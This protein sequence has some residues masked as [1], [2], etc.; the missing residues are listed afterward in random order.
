MSTNLLSKAL[1]ATQAEL[2]AELQR[3]QDIYYN[4]S[5]SEVKQIPSDKLYDDLVK[6]YESRFGEYKSIGAEPRGKEKVV[7][8]VFMG[9]LKKARTAKELDNFLKKYPGKE[10]VIMDKID[11]ISILDEPLAA[12]TRGKKGLGTDVTRVKHYVKFPPI[13]D[14]MVRGELAIQKQLF[15]QKYKGRYEN[16]RNIIFGS[17]TADDSFDPNVVR[18]FSFLAY[19]YIDN[20]I[21]PQTEQLQI[22]EKL[23]FQTPWY[24]VVP[25]Q[26]G[27]ELL[28]LLRPMLEKRQQE[29]LFDLDGLVLY[30]NGEYD[31]PD[32][33]NPDHSISFKGEDAS[34]ITR[35]EYVHWEPSKGRKLKPDVKVQQVYIDGANVDWATGNNARFIVEN[36]IDTGAIVEIVR[37]GKIIPKIIKVLERAE[38]KLPPNSYWNESGA[39][40]MTSDNTD[41]VN[42]KKLRY[43]F[44]TMDIKYLGEKT[45]EKLYDAGIDTIK[46]FLNLTVEDV[47]N[48]QGFALAGATRIVE[49]I[50][51]GI[52][53]ANIA[54]I[55]A[56][57]G[58]IENFAEKKYTKIL[59]GFPQFLDLSISNSDYILK[60][61]SLGGFAETAVTFAENRTKLNEFL[62]LHTEIT[63]RNDPRENRVLNI[64][65]I[66]SPIQGPVISSIPSPRIAVPSPIFQNPGTMIPV[67]QGLG[68]TIPIIQNDRVS[69]ERKEI[70]NSE[71][72]PI[73]QNIQNFNLAPVQ[74]RPGLL[75]GKGVLFTGFRNKEL[76]QRI[77]MQGGEIKSTVNGKTSI[78]VVKDMNDTKGKF[79]KAEEINDKKPG[80]IEIISLE[81]F[82]T[83]YMS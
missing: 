60:L 22:L 64:P 70:L 3:L 2:E 35:V 7:L 81:D 29:S 68:T 78:L 19:R 80:S 77:V 62:D 13:T 17:I 18:D 37:S 79:A 21:R 65:N 67:V 28:N 27:A 56:A 26:T 57:S 75:A 66:P 39:E 45:I 42:V 74:K 24:T 4:A 15:A 54:L 47:V 8:P 9:S 46:A 16:S 23:G 69:E 63:Y 58:V 50:Q 43:F 82:M 38:V 5:L 51:A 31:F 53:N 20:Q 52:K 32:D 33:K 30:A 55:L 73:S 49:N 71:I 76:E 1:S 36:G 14:S 44:K 6:I 12:T 48:I 59:D 83:K 10:I 11:G 41:E 40:L 25:Y 61:Q 72:L 34:E